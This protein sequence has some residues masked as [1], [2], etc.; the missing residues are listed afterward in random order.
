M[1][2]TINVSGQALKLVVCL[3]GLIHYDM[4]YFLLMGIIK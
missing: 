3:K 1:I 2:I 4:L